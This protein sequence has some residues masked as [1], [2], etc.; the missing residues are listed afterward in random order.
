MP[1][2][3]PAHLLLV[4][5]TLVHGGAEAML[6]RLAQTLNPRIVRPVALCLKEAGPG[7]EVLYQNQI[8]VHQHLLAHKYDF[9]VA[10]RIIRL[11]RK[12][13]PACIMAVGSGGDRMFWSTLAGRYIDA[14]VIV[15]SHVFPTVDYQAFERINRFLYPWVDAFVALGKRH[16]EALIRHEKISPQ[17]LH[18]IR[19][20]IDVSR[21][22]IP[23]W[24]T[25]ARQRMGV[26]DPH[27][28]IIGHI[29]NLRPVKKQNLFI[30]AA[31]Q[32]HNLRKNA[33]FV[34]IG[35]GP[36]RSKVQKKINEIDPEGKFIKWLGAR[37]DVAEL[38]Q[39]MDIVC[40]TSRCECLSVAMLEAMATGKPFVAPRAGSLDEAL[41]DHHTGRFFDPPTADQLAKVLIEL[42][43]DP[44]RRKQIGRNA[45][46]K[47]ESD[48]TACQMAREFENLVTGLLHNHGKISQV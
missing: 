40:L 6:V 33:V 24:K 4:T 28:I 17:R 25:S 9:R 5:N 19:N 36:S 44:D 35:D 48:F 23:E 42:I 11:L 20:G 39:G 14:P 21:F 13:A 7:A 43:D 38:L 46:S 30:E 22:R 15:W 3:E 29:S 45:Q 47:I 41:I 1:L 2:N 27:K 37:D 12:Y 31:R 8:P 10:A 32:I 26:K 34:L 18:V 16:Q